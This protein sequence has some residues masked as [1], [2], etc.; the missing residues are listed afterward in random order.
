MTRKAPFGES[1]F[2]LIL[3]IGAASAGL[4]ATY[5]ARDAS[6]LPRSSELKAAVVY[7]ATL[8]AVWLSLQLGRYRGDPY[9][10]PLAGMLGGIGLIMTVRLQP[11]LVGLRG[12][13]VDLGD[14]QLAY[15]VAGFIIIWAISLFA[16]NPE[17]LAPYR[18][19]ILF[20]GVALLVVTA[21]IGTEIQGARLWL[22][23]GPVV[24]QSTEIVK[25]ALIVF[26]AAYLSQNLELVGSSWRLWRLSLPPLPYLAP[27]VIMC[28]LCT[29]ALMI[30]ND[31]GTA[32]LFFLVFMLML[33]AANGR[34][35]QFILGSALFVGAF[36]I[37]YLA[38]P[39]VR[40][41][42]D[43]WLDP[44]SNL[45]TGYQQIQAE[46]AMAAGG[47]LG[48]GLGKGSPWLIP[49]V[50]NDY[51]I[52]A[53]GEELGLVGVV[54]VIAIYMMIATRGV[55]IAR[56]APTPFLR[57][58]AIGLT[59]GLVVQSI[60]ILAGVLRLMPL[61]GVTLPF[62]AYGGSSILVTAVMIGA[63]MRISSIA[64]SVRRIGA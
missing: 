61:T 44:W 17:V 34:A 59:A 50:E 54:G 9:L 55:V 4:G 58:L 36:A 30:L 5:L 15:L 46:Y 24:I 48:V 60:I 20:A 56:S 64:V 35:S 31:L 12:L 22:S 33:Y 37:A 16:P 52:A 38:V 14:R 62:V 29:G 23:A 47:F 11:D 32:L 13:T 8:L 21:A 63:L 7:G 25:L 27:M 19:S 51:V 45:V 10:L 53:I 41:R 43:V 1:F 57:L 2:S 42:F 26:L 40:V 6:A 39:R 3:V 28:G 49:V 18:Y